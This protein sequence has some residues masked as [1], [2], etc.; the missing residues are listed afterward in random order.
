MAGTS[1]RDDREVEMV[2]LNAIKN[3][4]LHA[5]EKEVNAMMGWSKIKVFQT[6][7]AKALGERHPAFAEKVN[8]SYQVFTELLEHH[9]RTADLAPTVGALEL[10]AF[11]KQNG[12]KVAL[13]TGFYR[14][15]TDIILERLGWMQGL[16]ADY[17]AESA[18]AIIDCSVS[19]SDVAEG[20]PAPDMIFLAMKKLNI[21]QASEVIN[22][23]DTPS[24]LL[25]GKSAGVKLALGVAN[26]THTY[27]ELNALPN[28]GILPT[29]GH[30][31]EL[32]KQQ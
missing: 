14:K 2:F 16:N 5:D 1:V 31:I 29:V 4:G 27:E 21:T 6:L 13:T 22:I 10:F 15:V 32:L 24:D 28:D 12:I 9:Y 23:G 8:E 11:C 17:L 7:W 20:R 30:L 3:T 19:S 18:D 26:G 25:S